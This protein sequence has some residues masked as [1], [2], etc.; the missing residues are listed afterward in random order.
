[1]KGADLGELWGSSH[2]FD[3]GLKVCVYVRPMSGQVVG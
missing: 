3:I 1:M 2:K